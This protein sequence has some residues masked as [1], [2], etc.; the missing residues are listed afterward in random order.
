MSTSGLFITG[1]DT[2]VGKSL[3]A[4]ALML[5]LREAGLQVAGLKPVAAGCRATS[6]GLRND[7]AELLARC[8][9]RPWPYTTIN[10]YA[11]AP[12]VAPH[13]AAAE[14]GVILELAPLRGA[15]EE[16]AAAS[17]AVVVEGAGGWLVPLDDHLTLADLAVDLGLDVVLVVGLRLGCINH[18][19]LTAASI[20]GHGLRLAGWVANT[21]DPQVERATEQL[22][23]LTARLDAPCLGT[24]PH[25]V[26]ATPETI[27]PR[28]DISPLGIGPTAT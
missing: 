17:D 2:G 25:K 28:L 24:L 3:V 1:T 7:D 21:I 11:L 6:E 4:G 20:A 27:A 10:P 9:S 12:A 19:L 8:A 14:A 16:L 15:F 22:A 13:L 5:R 26:E 23:T 18:A